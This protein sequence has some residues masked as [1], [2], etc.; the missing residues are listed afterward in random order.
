VCVAFASAGRGS[1]RKKIMTPEK[2]PIYPNSRDNRSAPVFPNSF[3][4]LGHAQISFLTKAIPPCQERAT[5]ESRENCLNHRPRQHSFRLGR[6]LAPLFFEHARRNRSQQWDSS[7]NPLPG[8]FS[9][10]PETR[11]IRIF[12]FD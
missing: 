9:S 6:G 5:G 4:S 8:N 3:C 2:R 12:V 10:S 7:R 11:D 1:R